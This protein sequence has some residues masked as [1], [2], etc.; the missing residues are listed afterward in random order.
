MLAETRANVKLA[1]IAARTFV[2]GASLVEW[3]RPDTT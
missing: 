1:G 3:A 2:D